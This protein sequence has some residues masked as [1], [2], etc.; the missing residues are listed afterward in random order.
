MMIMLI[1][2]ALHIR[3]I[4]LKVAESYIE[5]TTRN[6]V[7]ARAR[8]NCSCT[9][10]F[11]YVRDERFILA[12][13]E[14]NV[15]LHVQ[16]YDHNWFPLRSFVSHAAGIRRWGITQSKTWA[17]YSCGNRRRFIVGQIQMGNFSRRKT[18]GK[19]F[20]LS[21]GSLYRPALLPSPVL[22]HVK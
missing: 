5:M 1:E 7:S 12:S 21:T 20:R 6:D 8:K 17:R 9:C 18:S 10:D 11:Y 2:S 13:R 14:A 19:C 3:R 16:V 4:K 15:C 22:P